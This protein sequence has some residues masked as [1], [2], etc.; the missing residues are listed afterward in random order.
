VQDRRFLRYLLSGPDFYA[1]VRNQTLPPGRIVRVN[2]RV[3]ARVVK[4]VNLRNGDVR[5]ILGDYVQ[6]STFKNV[7]EWLS[8]LRRRY[9]GKLPTKLVLLRILYD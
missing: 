9:H 5:K 3:R 1:I 8:H 2:E 6:Y 4:V 7:D